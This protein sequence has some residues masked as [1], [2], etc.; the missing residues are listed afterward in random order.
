MHLKQESGYRQER[1]GKR[2]EITSKNKLT[3][4]V[5]DDFFPFEKVVAKNG[6]IKWKEKEKQENGKMGKKSG[7]E[8]TRKEGIEE[9]YFE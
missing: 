3:P 7:E 4:E 8:K 5:V 1:N 6:S 9:S 2:L